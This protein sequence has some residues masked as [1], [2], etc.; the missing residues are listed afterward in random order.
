MLTPPVGALCAGQTAAFCAAHKL[1]GMVNNRHKMC[2]FPGCAS[3][4]T[5]KNP[6]DTHPTF[7]GAHRTEGMVQ[8]GVPS[9]FFLIK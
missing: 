5:F 3:H 8:A 7:C 4:A 9:S 6:G 2:T 1:E